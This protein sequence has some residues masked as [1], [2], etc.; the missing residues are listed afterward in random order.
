M[1]TPKKRVSSDIDKNLVTALDAK[2][3]KLGISR[4]KFI[5][6]A[7]NSE[8]GRFNVHK[9]NKRLTRRIETAE[10]DIA[11]LQHQLDTAKEKLDYADELLER[12]HKNLQELEREK[13]EL[14]EQAETLKQE[15]AT[16]EAKYEKEC[17]DR[18]KLSE[19]YTE[20]IKGIATTLGVPPTPMHIKQRIGELEQQVNDLEASVENREKERDTFKAKFETADANYRTCNEKLNL[21]LTRNWWERLWNILPW[22]E[23]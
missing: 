3:E 16:A 21:L 8:L 18:Q 6:I 4:S 22:I 1:G 7:L 10:Q 2:R 12:K 5:E 11:E 20:Q 15:R 23:K 19:T 14:T 17:K 9:E 13:R